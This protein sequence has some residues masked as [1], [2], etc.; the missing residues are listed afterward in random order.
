MVGCRKLDKKKTCVGPH[1][2]VY[3]APAQ[4]LCTTCSERQKH[5]TDGVRNVPRY[6]HGLY[7]AIYASYMLI[8]F[9]TLPRLRP[10]SIEEDTYTTE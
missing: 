2:L 8:K 5:D 9:N 3:L 6:T 7:K 10:T 4:A 1:T